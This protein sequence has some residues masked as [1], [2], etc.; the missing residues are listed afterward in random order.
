MTRRDAVAGLALLA[1]YADGVLAP[2]EDDALRE[3]L[4]TFPLFEQMDDA[5][6]GRFLATL[7]SLSRERGGDELFEAC[8]DALDERLRPTAFLVAADVVASDGKVEP[9]ESA[10]LARLEK[11]LA[12]PRAQAE[13]ILDVTRIRRQV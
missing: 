13:A 6:L 7:E 10:F 5:E 12:I 3:H 9:S 11:R 4:L 1:M 2:E 8:C